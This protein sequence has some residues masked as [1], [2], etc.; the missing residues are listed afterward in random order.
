MERTG[1][2][3]HGWQKFHEQLFEICRRPVG[4]HENS[5]METRYSP[6]IAPPMPGIVQCLEVLT[7]VRNKHAPGNRRGEEVSRVSRVFEP[8][9]DCTLDVVPMAPKSFPTTRDMSWS[10]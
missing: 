5:G 9:I 8:Q 1:K 7:V 10:N 2:V 3:V 6:C 4:Y